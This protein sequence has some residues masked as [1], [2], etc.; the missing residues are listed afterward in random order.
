MIMGMPVSIDITNC[1]NEKHF[2][3]AFNK[4]REID[5]QFSPYKPDSELSKYR[6]GELS[7]DELSTDM[8]R[9]QESCA[10]YELLTKGYFSAYYDGNF[11]PSGY[12]K[13]WAIQQ[14]ANLFA[15]KGIVTFL[16]NI[17]GDIL[18]RSDGSKNWTIAIQDPISQSQLLGMINVKNGAVTTSGLYE[19]GNHIIN[20]LTKRT[21]KQLISA[22]VYG[23][24][25]ITADVLATTCIA[26]GKSKAL[27][28][29]ESQP[30]YEAL[31][32]D[33]KGRVYTTKRFINL[34]KQIV[35]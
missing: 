23:K 32:I 22:S 1:K 25:I 31:L 33:K 24:N 21:T 34:K 2:T 30:G 12:V 4:L 14:V 3:D 15:S 26:M 35:Q 17:G 5:L 20:P 6:R 19:R 10:Q 13:S 28:F 7:Q 9:I 29:M 11:E 18:A 8:L 27:S 16:I